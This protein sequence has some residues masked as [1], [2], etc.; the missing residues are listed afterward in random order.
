MT[1]PL[2]VVAQY[3]AQYAVPSADQIIADANAAID[4]AVKLFPGAETYE[5]AIADRE[6]ALCYL[7]RST[8]RAG[9][10]AE[11]LRQ[12]LKRR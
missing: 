1:Y 4:E 5:H 6:S 12:Q 9:M 2:E 10:M 11:A 3:E 8:Y 7:L